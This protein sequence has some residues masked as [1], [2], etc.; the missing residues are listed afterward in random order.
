MGLH[1]YT[2]LSHFRRMD[3]PIKLVGASPPLSSTYR[4]IL[5]S[6][7]HIICKWGYFVA[8]Q[9]HGSGAQ[10]LSLLRVSPC[11]SLITL[12][13]HPTKSGALG[14]TPVLLDQNRALL[15]SIRHRCVASRTL[16]C[17][18]VRSRR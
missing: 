13:V 15:G 6:F 16:S 14:A 9:H 10:L 11:I 8:S 3:A 12:K 2:I 7:H 1:T 4:L 5:V 18:L 17:S